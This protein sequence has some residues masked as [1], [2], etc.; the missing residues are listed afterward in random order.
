MQAFLGL[1]C[2]MAIA[3]LFS[4]NRKKFP[5]KLA[6]I[7]ILS[8]FLIASLFLKLESLNDIFAYIN[9]FVSLIEE[10]SAY[11]SKFVFGYLSGAKFPAAITE[12]D[13]LFIIAFKVMPIIIFVSALSSLFFHLGIIPVL[14][15]ALGKVLRKLFKINGAIGFAL[16]ASL[17]LGTIEAPLTIKS[18]LSKLSKSDLFLMITASMSTISGGVLVLYSSVLS[19]AVD[20]A[21]SH[22]VIASI[23]S[24]PAAILIAR[25]MVP[26]QSKDAFEEPKANSFRQNNFMEAIIKGTEEGTIMVL[27][28]TATIMVLFSLVYFFD[29]ILGAF[30]DTLSIKKLLS[31][32]FR[33]LMWLCGISWKDSLIAASLFGEKVVLNEFVAYLSLAKIPTDTFTEHSKIVISYALCGFANFASVGIIISGLKIFMPDDKKALVTKLVTRALISGNLATLMTASMVSI[34]LLIL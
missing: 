8:Q 10:S 2:F 15:A 23:M 29:S 19:E 4:E 12:S 25:I 32:I 20:N 21:A 24:L 31:E 9:S 34:S 7:A 28:I 1:F 13:A 30:S 5:F 33:P 27:N 18:Y 26:E 3:S 14:I 16:A 11:G 6:F 22:L 17:F